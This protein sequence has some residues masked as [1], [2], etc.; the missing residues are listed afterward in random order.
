MGARLDDGFSSTIT[1]ENIPSVKLYEKDVTPPGVNMGGAI[2]ITTMRNTAWRT[3]SPKTL[4]AL[5]A[6]SAT[7]AYA[8]E[9][10][11]NIIAQIGVNQPIT[12]TFPDDS[13]IEFWG[14]LEEFTPGAL[15]EG[16][17]PTANITIQPSLVNG[18]GTEVAPVY[19][20]S[21]ES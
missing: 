1:L 2:D 13:T 14:W 15:T 11:E 4:K 9:A 16:E 18:A 7:V 3:Q 21:G 10:Y 20:A 17:Q 12:I 8:V 5:A 19:A 6:V